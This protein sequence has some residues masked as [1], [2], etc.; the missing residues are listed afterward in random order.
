MKIYASFMLKRI[1]DNDKIYVLHFDAASLV[2]FFLFI[3]RLTP[4]MEPCA[5]F[6]YHLFPGNGEKKVLFMCAFNFN[7]NCFCLING[8][9]YCVNMVVFDI[10]STEQVLTVANP[11]F[12][13]LFIQ[14]LQQLTEFHVTKVT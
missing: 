5:C 13:K 11:N 14:F 12:I 9:L 10:F 6:C 4:F 3:F 2:L 1:Y 8:A 7:W